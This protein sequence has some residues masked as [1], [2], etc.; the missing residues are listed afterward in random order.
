MEQFIIKG[1]CHLKGSVKISGSKNAALPIIAA[2][3]LFKEPLTIRNVPEIKDVFSIINILEELGAVA[4]FKNNTLN[5]DPTRIKDIDPNPVKVRNLRASIL[6]IAPLLIRNKKVSLPHPG[7]CLIGSR[8]V[9]VHIEAF[10]KMGAKFEQAAEKYVLF[11]D[12]LEGKELSADFSVTGT[13]NIVMAAVLSKEVTT[14]HLAAAEPH[15]QDLCNFLVTAGAKIEGIG[16]HDL[17]ITGVKELK[18]VDYE[19]IADQI[20]AGTFAIAAAATKGDVKIDG[21]IK[22]H[23]QS[24]LSKFDKAGV[25]YKILNDQTIEIKPSHQIKPFKIRTEIYPGFPTDLQAPMAVLATQANGTTE[26]YETIFEGRLGYVNELSKM[27]ASC[28]IRDA[29]HASITGPS[30]LYGTRITSF[31]LRAGATLI[32]A[33]LIAQ[34]ESRLDQIEVIDRGYEKIEKKLKQLGADIRRVKLQEIA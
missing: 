2:T 1:P 15:V 5:I 9:D 23:H 20:E 8:P 25:N 10:I 12:K 14:I 31:D 17:I 3:A 21:F 26:I 6:I 7:G 34:G 30:P 32:I 28:I 27:G 33:G 22:D 29:H 16:T 4:S 18:G 19:I 13:E 24:L 11:A